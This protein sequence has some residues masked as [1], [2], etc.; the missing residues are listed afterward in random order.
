[1][2]DSR[3]SPHRISTIV[4]AAAL[5]VFAAAPPT[6]FADRG[7]CGQPTSSGPNP[8]G[9]D[10]L[11]V[12]KSAV[13]LPTACDL[14]PCICDVD[15][16]GSVTV[17]DAL[18][19]L[20]KAVGQPVE[21]QCDCPSG[22]ACTSAEIFTMPGSDLDTGWTGI[23]HNTEIIEGASITFRG[24]KRCSD[25]QA[26][27]RRD[28][29]CT[30][31]DCRLTCDC[32]GGDTEC[33]ITGPTHGRNCL[34]T[35]AHCE[36]NADCAAGV[37]CVHTFGPP[38]PLSSGGNPVC[39]VSYFTGDI[40]GTADSATGEG[41][42]SVNLRSRVFLGLGLGQ[43][44]PRCG[45]PEE[46]PAVGDTFTCEGGQFP[47]AACT[48]EGV[49]PDFGGVSRDCPPNLNGSISGSGLAV[50]FGEVTTGTSTRTAALP[51]SDFSFQSHPSR[52]NG[53]CIDDDT[54]CSSN[55][56]CTRCSE[57]PTTD[58]TSNA[59]CGGK[60]TCAEAPDQPVTCGYWCHCGFCNNNPSL[61]CFGNGDCPNGETCVAG[62]G[63]PAAQNAP[64]K[65]PNECIGD[66]F[67]CGMADDE[68]CANTLRGTCSLESFRSCNE[69]STC[70]DNDAGTCVFDFRP[71]FEPRITR[72][73][74]PSP[75]GSY[76][77]NAA[78][79]STCAT[80]AECG[81]GDECVADSSR[82]TTVALFCAPATTSGPINST[83]GLTGPGAVTF[84][85]FIKVC[86]C[87]DGDVGCDEQCDDGDLDSGDGCDSECELEE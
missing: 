8:A 26:V 5:G 61:P 4:L 29:D 87:G 66:K 69:D 25:T 23:A 58:C 82:P 45:P 16:D 56:D 46:E 47:G 64:Q 52:G 28:E 15:G 78:D 27:C 7:D 74:E 37:A 68:K 22:P 65:L 54:A 1:M 75:L 6:A 36:T 24:L 20:R 38:L 17:K 77:R 81:A 19:L 33:E 43:P 63:G 70:L 80:N 73:G 83:G 50:R 44:C 40:T 13:G 60:G 62:G 32:N 53:K 21:L 31:H 71:C 2:F 34:T 41:V 49:S 57:D 86:R 67:I 10:A 79:D 30:N 48:V 12:L 55:A 3:C 35:L 11:T 18:L 84:R 51:C 76:C 42:A 39:I 59:D 72:S 9:S 85:S 14:K